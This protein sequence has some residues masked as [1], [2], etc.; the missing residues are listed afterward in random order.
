ML[1]ILVKN[2]KI[3]YC[4]TSVVAWLNKNGGDGKNKES[5]LLFFEKGSS[6]IMNV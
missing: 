6:E 4:P 3:V 1:T 5:I 2:D